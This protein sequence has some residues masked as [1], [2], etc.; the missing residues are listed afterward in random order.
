M[1]LKQ[2][3]TNVVAMPLSFK[4]SSSISISTNPDVELVEI[5]Q[6]STNIAQTGN[7]TSTSPDIIRQ[8]LLIRPITPQTQQQ[9]QIQK[10]ANNT[11]ISN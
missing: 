3:R 4:R 1:C 8:Q 11:D 9:F 5:A 7:A 2:S 10:V 6:S